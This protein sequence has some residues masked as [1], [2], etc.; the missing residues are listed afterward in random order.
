[1][2][3]WF[4]TCQDLG[5]KKKY[6]NPVSR[7]L[8][9]N[10]QASEW[11]EACSTLTTKYMTYNVFGGLYQSIFLSGAHFLNTGKAQF[12]SAKIRAWDAV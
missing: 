6:V 9:T 11:L 12:Q 1:M 4:S 7:C 8:E 3:V 2:L 5:T 10:T